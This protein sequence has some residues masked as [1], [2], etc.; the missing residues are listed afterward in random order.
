NW[1]WHNIKEIKS[2]EKP[3]VLSAHK[4]R[5]LEIACRNLAVNAEENNRYEEASRFRYMA[6]EARRLEKW[7]G[8][9]FWTLGWWYWLAS[10][11]GERVWLA[12]AWLIGIWLL[13]AMFYVGLGF[14]NRELSSALLYSAG[15][16]TL[17]KPEP[18]PATNAA[19]S[20]V[21]LE[22]I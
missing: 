18:R 17:K 9:A 8:F 12:F 6:M 3:F 13:S 10:G 11:Y 19:Q 4:H 1:N 15:V 5:L 16:M 14:P 2:L 20:L 22:T 7:R 21:M